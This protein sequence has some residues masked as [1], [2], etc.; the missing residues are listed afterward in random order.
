MQS[1]TELGSKF[2]ADHILAHSQGGKTDMSNIQTLQVTENLIKGSGP[3]LRSW[4]KDA[5]QTLAVHEGKYFNL[6]VVYGAGKTLFGIEAFKQMRTTSDLLIIVCPTLA[7]VDGWVTDSAKHGIQLDGRWP[8]NGLSSDYHGI[9]MTYQSLLRN[10]EGLLLLQK[11]GF[12]LIVELDECHHNGSDKATGLAINTAFSYVR[13]IL[14]LSGT[15]FRHDDSLIYGG[16]LEGDCYKTHFQ[17]SYLDA[18]RDNI[19]RPCK[20]DLINAYAIIERHDGS[21]FDIKSEDSEEGLGYLVSAESVIAETVKKLIDELKYKQSIKPDAAVLIVAKD[22]YHAVAISKEWQR[23]YGSEASVVTSDDSEASQKLDIFKR[24]IGVCLISVK[25]V[26][27]GVNIPRICIIGILSNCTTALFFRQLVGR[28]IRKQDNDAPSMECTVIAIGTA[29]NKKHAEEIEMD[30][31]ICFK[32]AKAKR[33]MAEIENRNR[34]VC[35]VVSS[36]ITGVETIIS[37]EKIKENMD[38]LIK[39]VSGQTNLP[40]QAVNLVL[41]RASDLGILNGFS[42]IRQNEDSSAYCE[43]RPAITKQRDDLSPRI[44]SRVGYLAKLTGE[45]HRDIHNRL[46]AKI[47]VLGKDDPELN[48]EKLNKKLELVCDEI[49]QAKKWSTI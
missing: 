33:D 45:E 8:G 7:I 10:V 49:T 24:G 29:E 1:G 9:A 48:L 40:Y 31:K 43:S 18:L 2:H 4:Q 6:E 14:N 22:I 15:F 37:G 36:G 27:E 44:N 23:Q 26:S 47:G 41:S 11:K 42:V 46:N 35:T 3:Q 32:E 17:Y 5:L 25:M 30:V 13:R 34:Q 38:A 12:R 19:V 28:G 16:A 39:S 21:R 20:F